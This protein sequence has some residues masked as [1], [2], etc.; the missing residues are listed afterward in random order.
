M[1]LVGKMGSVSER[2]DPGR[3]PRYDENRGA[4]VAAKDATIG[5]YSSRRVSDPGNGGNSNRAA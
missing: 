1:D 4:E 5:I 2:L 3:L